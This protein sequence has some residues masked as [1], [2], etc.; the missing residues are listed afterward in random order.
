MSGNYAS[1]PNLKGFAIFFGSAVLIVG[2]GAIREGDWQ[3]YVIVGSI[4]S[5]LIFPRLKPSVF[6]RNES[7]LRNHVFEAGVLAAILLFW[8]GARRFAAQDA[9]DV[10]LN[11]YIGA[12]DF[13][14]LVREAGHA[15]WTIDRLNAAH[16]LEKAIVRKAQ[17]QSANCSAIG[18]QPFKRS[19]QVLV[20]NTQ[21]DSRH[22]AQSW[23]AEG[24]DYQRGEGPLT[25]FLVSATRSVQVGTYSISG[26]P[27]FR[28]WVDVCVV[29]F[30]ALSDP[31]KPLAS[32]QVVSLDPAQSRQVRD[33][34][35]YG[36]AARPVADW[37]QH[38]GLIR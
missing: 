9:F 19:A 29:Q 13:A 4:L 1:G 23:L 10:R 32:H 21:E 34:P 11:T 35:E 28:Q 31:G 25:V 5:L 12:N 30:D 36:D 16:A 2:I 17:S 24:R 15:S 22:P 26:Q 14:S 37:I 18:D 7:A 3:G 27:A 20:W 6:F 33:A 38:D 8:F